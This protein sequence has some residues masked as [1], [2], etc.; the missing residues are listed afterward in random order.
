M[1]LYAVVMWNNIVT[2]KQFP[3][4][5]TS[6]PE[7]HLVPFALFIKTSPPFWLRLSAALSRGW[8]RL[9]SPLPHHYQFEARPS[10]CFG[11]SEL[12]SFISARPTFVHARSQSCPSGRKEDP[13]T[14]A[15]VDTRARLW[16]QI[17]RMTSWSLSR[18]A[19]PAILKKLFEK[20]PPLFA[21]VLSL[22]CLPE[23]HLCKRQYLTCRLK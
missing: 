11:F 12:W 6:H 8:P 23:S 9:S 3:K 14:L 17:K 4:A 5:N 22:L 10:L 1:N 2:Y 13:M 18:F 7:P 20:A 15:Q 19:A 21:H 16:P